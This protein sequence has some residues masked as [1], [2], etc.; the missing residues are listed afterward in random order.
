MAHQEGR[1]AKAFC[2]SAI[3]GAVSVRARQSK[4]KQRARDKWV[5]A[6]RHR[7]G[8]RY[9]NPHFADARHY[10]CRHKLGTWRCRYSGRP[11]NQSSQ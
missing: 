10:H 3:V 6:V 11:C 1:S 5:N 9:A 8:N 4:A 7:Y 2:K